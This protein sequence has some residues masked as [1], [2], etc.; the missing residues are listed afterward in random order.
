[1]IKHVLV[2]G[3]LLLPAPGAR[4]LAAPAELIIEAEE[5]P[6]ESFQASDG[7]MSGITG[8]L[9]RRA[10]ARAGVP[11]AIGPV[12]WQRAYGDALANPLTCA[13]PTTETPERL[14]LFKWAGPLAHND[15]VLIGTNEGGIRLDRLEDAKRYR[16]GVY[17]GDAREE[18][19]RKAG[20]YQIETVNGNQLNLTRLEAGRIDLW[21][22]SVYTLWYERQHGAANLKV[23]L[24]FRAVTLS[25]ACNRSVPDDTMARLNRAIAAL[26]DDGTVA[27]IEAPYR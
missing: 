27:A 7:Q 10:L 16:I 3:L 25:L 13:Y 12:P 9:L 5:T 1:M 11:A 19:F 6:P 17:Q 2:L 14:P 24:P 8:E 20:G 18:F 22:A 26:I 4:A 21:A 23:V 15:W